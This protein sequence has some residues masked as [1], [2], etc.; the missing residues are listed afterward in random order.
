MQRAMIGFKSRWVTSRSSKRGRPRG[1]RYR[2]QHR[3]TN[4]R[5]TIPTV[6]GRDHQPSATQ[7]DKPRVIRSCP[8]SALKQGQ[9]GRR[10]GDARPSTPRYSPSAFLANGQPNS[11]RFLSLDRRRGLPLQGASNLNSSRLGQLELRSTSEESP[12]ASSLNA[13]A[14]PAAIGAV[15]GSAWSSCAAP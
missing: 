1:R 3:L 7:R 9:L 4:C 10:S 15:C 2:V 14:W 11:R 13:A 6:C 5:Q 8:R 12:A